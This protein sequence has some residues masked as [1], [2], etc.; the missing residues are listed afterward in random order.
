MTIHIVKSGETLFSIA[1]E[2]SVDPNILAIN[3]GIT[4]NRRLAIGQSLIIVFP[5]TTHIVRQGETLFT[6]AQNYGIS[7]NQIYRNNL[8]LQGVPIINPG[9]QLT[10]TTNSEIVGSYMTGGYAYPFID[11]TLLNTTLPFMSGLMPFTYGFNEDGSLVLLN[12][13]TL[14][15]RAKIYGT[16]PVMHL[17]T[18]TEEGN[19][20]VEL[21]ESFLNNRGVWDTLIDNV[22]II[23]RQ[24]GYYGLDI[25]FEFLGAANAVN[26]AAFVG[27]TRNRLNSQGYPVL[28]ALAPKTRVDQPGILYEGHDYRALGNA[29]NTVLLMT[30]EWGYTFGPPMAV[31]P[32]KQVSAVIE[33]ALTQID[34][35]KIF[36][37]ISNYGYDFTLPYVAGESQAP[38]LSTIEANAIAALYNAVIIYDEEAQAPYFRYYVNGTQHIVWY[39]DVRSLQARLLLLEKYDLRGA[40]YWNLDRPNPQNLVLLNSMFNILPLNLF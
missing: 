27:L 11:I 24:K 1:R 25:D 17:S 35:N 15:A 23:I 38:S 26:Y 2:Y 31:S 6:I 10:I 14:V 39:E 34:N 22:L 29:A 8:I 19:F 40:L 36:L 16:R 12:D 37:G 20:S 7:V 3:N 33:F 30:Y 32:I 13:N 9:L 5:Q 28:V 4:G 21:A 18:L